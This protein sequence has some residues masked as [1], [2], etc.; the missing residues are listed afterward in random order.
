[1]AR[2]SEELLC[3]IDLLWSSHELADGK[4]RRLRLGPAC[5]A[6]R[7]VDVRTRVGQIETTFEVDPMENPGHF[8]LLGLSLRR[9]VLRCG[10][11]ALPRDVYSG[12]S[13]VVAA[14]AL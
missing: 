9:R 12:Y 4:S 8:S 1:M 6:N 10:E 7:T 3:R 11:G 14:A 5:L 2:R 13:E